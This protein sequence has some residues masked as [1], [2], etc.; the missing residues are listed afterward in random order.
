MVVDKEETNFLVFVQKRI[1]FEVLG[2]S[3]RK[4][5]KRSLRRWN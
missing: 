2:V 1:V 5:V 4:V 3:F